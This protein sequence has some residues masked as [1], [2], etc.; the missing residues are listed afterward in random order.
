VGRFTPARI[1]FQ[2]LL[3][4]ATQ[5]IYISTP[6]FLPDHALRDEITRAAHE[7][8]VQVRIV[9]PGRRSDHRMVWH[10]SRRLYGELLRSGVEIFE[11]EPSMNH[12]KS[13]MVDGLW[14]VVGSTNM[15]TRS[16]G[17]NDE[18]NLAVRDASLTNRLERDF[19]ADVARS[20]PVLYEEWRNRGPIRRMQEWIGAVFERQE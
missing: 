16:F 7:R 20:R 18:V 13:L 11:Y 6:Y 8:H 9:V 3:A 4:S 12:T 1:L 10:A 17:L 19:L 15:D 5:R 2:T 14:S